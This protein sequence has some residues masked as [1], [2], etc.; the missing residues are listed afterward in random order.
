MVFMKKNDPRR[1]ILSLRISDRLRDRIE[2]LRK[3]LSSQI[4]K[5]VSTAEAACYMLEEQDQKAEEQTEFIELLRAPTQSL[6]LARKHWEVSRHLSRAEWRLLAE[7]IQK[8]CEHIS[9]QPGTPTLESVLDLFHAFEAVYRY[10]IRPLSL[11]LPYYFGNLDGHHHVGMETFE[12]ADADTRYEMV[13]KLVAQAE[14]HL[15]GGQPS[16][17][18][19]YLSRCFYVAVR[20]EKIDDI[21]LDKLLAEHWTG[22]WRIAA[23]G[24]WLSE[25]T[26]IRAITLEEPKE[27][28]R[29][30]LPAQMRCAG[31]YEFYPSADERS[32]D[33]LLGIYFLARSLL[34]PIS[35]YPKLA[36]FRAM[37]Q[38]LRP[39]PE[40][41][42]KVWN[43]EQF[44]AHRF[45]S[46]ESD[47][48]R[49]GC[50]AHANG[51]M[52]YFSEEEWS[53]LVELCDQLW[54]HPAW[55]ERWSVL[56]DE[57]GEHG[58]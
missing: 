40:N 18:L 1:H 48:I 46:E 43:G 26:P 50:R 23:R 21:L 13:L 53:A 19:N 52:L 8:G 24:H 38:H 2:Q 49:Y 6:A 17:L 51:I 44:F 56:V 7:Y 45:R 30:R 5:D 27:R 15:R 25:K 32:G 58:A 47:A 3:A 37:L 41:E 34:Y 10:G 28:Y 4:G 35:Y 22:L 9:I 16:S 31:L 14:K 11:H 54:Q 29:H 55:I 36:G 12:Q 57:Y 33:L 20:D 39:S 42:D